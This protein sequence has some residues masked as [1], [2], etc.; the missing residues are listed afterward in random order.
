MITDDYFPL[1]LQMIFSIFDI[2]GVVIHF[3]FQYKT[4][5]NLITFNFATLRTCLIL[6]FVLC[7]RK[8]YGIFHALTY[9]EAFPII[10]TV[11]LGFSNGYLTSFNLDKLTKFENSGER[12]TTAAFLVTAI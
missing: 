12:D 5:R 4:Y 8:K 3:K 7:K 9:H 6:L 1:Y 11:I 10:Y 2:I